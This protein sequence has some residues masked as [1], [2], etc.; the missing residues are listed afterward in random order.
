MPNPS[1]TWRYPRKDGRVVTRDELRAE[2]GPRLCY[3]LVV[4]KGMWADRP[5][6]WELKSRWGDQPVLEDGSARTKAAS[7]RRVL[8]AMRWDVRKGREAA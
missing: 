5:W 2:A 8:D 1:P 4:R 3:L 7:Q 6:R